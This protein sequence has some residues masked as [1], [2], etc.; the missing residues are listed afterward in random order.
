MIFYH[1]LNSYKK[2]G[3]DK[4]LG[5]KG[6]HIWLKNVFPYSGMQAVIL[7]F[8]SCSLTPFLFKEYNQFF[9]TFVRKLAVFN[10]FFLL[11]TFVLISIPFLYNFRIRVSDMLK[12][13]RPARAIIVFNTIVKIVLSVVLIVTLSGAYSSYTIISTQFSKSLERWEATRDYAIIPVISNIT[14]DELTSKEFREKQ[15]KLYLNF[16]KRGAI[17]ADFTEFRPTIRV[18]RMK[19][20]DRSFK[21]D[22]VLVN[23][24]YLDLYPI[25]GSS[26][27]KIIVSENENEYLLLIPEKYKVSENEI[28]T[29]FQFIKRGYGDYID[30]KMLPCAMSKQSIKIIWTKN[31][32]SSFSLDVTV[33]PENGNMVKEPVVRVL[34]ESNGALPDYDKILAYLGNPLKMKID[35]QNDADASIRPDFR[36]VGLD[37]FIPNI[38]S[39]YDAVSGEVK[40]ERDNLVMLVVLMMVLLGVIVTIIGQSVYNYFEQ[41]KLRLAIQKFH[42]YK[43][44][45][46]YKGYFL[47]VGVSWIFTAG[48]TAFTKMIK[49]IDLICFSV[50]FFLLEMVLTVM[51]IGIVERRKVL[52]ITKGG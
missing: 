42:G 22:T 27:R 7:I 34:T 26:G 39:V 29:Y 30:G 52:K 32:Q 31:N 12:N 23:K 48:I 17:L 25:Y 11:W 15:K 20:A 10:V 21:R 18:M 45:D 38:L 51:S 1:V 6:R 28:R 40:I 33:N 43:N 14:N 19:E 50:A 46:K 47:I 41:Y 49:P 35:K 5:F 4:M 3:I 24:N 37:Q 2:I 44:W 13:K 8:I 16:N 36:A 9:W